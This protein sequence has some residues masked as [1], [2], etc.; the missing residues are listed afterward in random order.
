[1]FKHVKSVLSKKGAVVLL[2]ITKLERKIIKNK[3]TCKI[4]LPRSKK[5]V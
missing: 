3:N 2:K 5:W 4:I 1:M